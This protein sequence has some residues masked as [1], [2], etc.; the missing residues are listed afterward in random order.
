MADWQEKLSRGDKTLICKT[1]LKPFEKL[2]NLKIHEKNHTGE[3]PF[4][5]SHCEKKFSQLGT[6]KIHERI[7]TGGK[8]FNS[9]VFW[10][11]VK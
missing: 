9:A 7:H 3:R 8:P 2:S 6:L 4:G 1:C 11:I 5:C 10:E